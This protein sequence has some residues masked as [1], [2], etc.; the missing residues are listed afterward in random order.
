MYYCVYE[1]SFVGNL[2]RIFP[3]PFP[4]QH[5]NLEKEDRKHKCFLKQIRM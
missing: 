4:L 3:L 2:E 5:N 1:Q